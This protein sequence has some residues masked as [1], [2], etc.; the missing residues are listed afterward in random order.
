MR[1]PIIVELEK[2]LVN[3]KAR[4]NLYQ[5]LLKEDEDIQKDEEMHWMF[6]DLRN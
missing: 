6:E 3:S 2:E 4:F 5:R 1:T